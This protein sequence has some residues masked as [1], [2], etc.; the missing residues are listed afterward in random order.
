MGHGWDRSAGQNDGFRPLDHGQDAS[1][2]A[3]A[4]GK[5]SSGHGQ[6]L[7]ACSDILPFNFSSRLIIS[8]KRLTDG[9]SWPSFLR[10][11]VT[12]KAT[13]ISS[14]F[15]LGVCL[16]LSL[17]PSHTFLPVHLCVCVRVCVCTHLHLCVCVSL[18]WHLCASFRLSSGLWPELCHR[19]L[20]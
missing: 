7:C 11:N 19:S 2:D 12:I 8:F 3:T 18:F 13:K 15:C 5:A 6:T 17:S 9:V 10:L 20:F 14:C 1:A 16:H 4:P